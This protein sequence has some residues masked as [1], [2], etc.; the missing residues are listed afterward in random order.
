MTFWNTFAIIGIMMVMLKTKMKK[1]L[2]I[3]M[4]FAL[5]VVPIL[6]NVLM[7]ES[8]DGISLACQNSPACMEAVE[9]EQEA[10][11]N[12]ASASSSVNL[13]QAKVNE[14]NIEIAS[15][16]LE[17]AETEAQVDDLNLQIKETEER[18]LAE[19][20]ALAE[21]L[22]GMH[23][24]GDDEPIIILAGASSISDLA[25]KQARSEVVKQQISA[26][27][28]S[29]K[30]AK[31]KLEADKEQVEALLVQQQ[32]SKTELENKRAE[33]Q[34]LVEKYQNDVEAYNEIAEAAKEAQ[35][36]AER[37]EQETH[38]ERYQ[39]SSYNGVNTYPWQ[40]DC[41]QRQDDYGTVWNGYYIGGYVCEC[42]SYAGWKAYET[43]GLVIAWGNAYS[44]DDRA[45]AYGYVV[46]NTPAPNTIGQVDGYPYGH[47]F[48][49]ESVNADGSIN[50]TEYNNAYATQL[51]SGIF[52]Y[53]DFGAR[54]ISANEVANYN[55]I[56][57]R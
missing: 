32:A 56:H 25:E 11:R 10:N 16:E 19:Q 35:R 27:A 33:Q 37:I 21:L 3:G 38:P 46:N 44:W 15:R 57:L 34:A 39:G 17:I 47:V 24:E 4:I 48:W 54:T 45:R 30:E 36:E 8:A 26:T 6:T 14:L 49:V 12:A 29:V 1:V 31:E 18:L 41:P 40:A 20:E 42:V 22:I 28:Q 2:I 43:F 51:Y 13:F 50:V 7:I 52:R 5:S 55:Y 23:F 9:K 53:G